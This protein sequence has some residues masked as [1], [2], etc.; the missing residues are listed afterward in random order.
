MLRARGSSRGGARS[1]PLLWGAPPA[2][3]RA[4]GTPSLRLRLRRPGPQ[5][6]LQ[7]G[8]PS[9]HLGELWPLWRATAARAIVVGV[10]GVVGGVGGALP[11]DLHGQLSHACPQQLELCLYPRA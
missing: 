10:V 11:V 9:P 8:Y 5:L 2:A 1:P 4:D 6:G 7:L 3:Q